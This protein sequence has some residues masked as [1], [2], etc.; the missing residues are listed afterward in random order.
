[1][2]NIPYGAGIKYDFLH[3]N[4]NYKNE[5][6]FLDKLFKQYDTNNILDNNQFKLL[7]AK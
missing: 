1:M 7:E 2:S 3:S 6:L 5:V 4:K